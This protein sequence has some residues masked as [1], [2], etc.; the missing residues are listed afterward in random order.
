MAGNDSHAQSLTRLT[1]NLT[2]RATA[3][4]ELA[5][6]L[7]GDSKTDTVCRALQ[8]YAYIEQILR[9]GGAVYVRETTDGNL[10]R[11]QVL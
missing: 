4:M 10:E 11:V 2:P 6:G 5:A 7:T 1:V 3:A 8:V 9:G